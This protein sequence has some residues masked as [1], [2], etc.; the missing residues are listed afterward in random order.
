VHR[1]RSDAT[2]NS[3]TPS[4]ARVWI[5][6][7]ELRMRGRRHYPASGSR[8]RVVRS[9]SRTYLCGERPRRRDRKSCSPQAGVCTAGSR[10][11]GCGGSLR[12]GLEAYRIRGGGRASARSGPA[13]VRRTPPGPPSSCIGNN[14]VSFPLTFPRRCSSALRLRFRAERNGLENRCGPFGPPRVRILPLRSARRASRRLAI[15]SRGTHV[16]PRRAGHREAAQVT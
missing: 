5:K 15:S 4:S 2:A 3:K 9:P 1:V 13:R 11:A 12:Q 14:R 7:S 16:R 10:G 8:D 6:T